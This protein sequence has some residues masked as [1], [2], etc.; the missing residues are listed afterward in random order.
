MEPDQP[1]LELL[2]PWRPLV[3]MLHIMRV[4][5]LHIMKVLTL[6]IMKVFMEVLKSAHFETAHYESVFKT[7]MEVL[8]LHIMKVLMLHTL[9]G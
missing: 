7:E 3:L 4:L 9:P 2:S 5:T 8:T 6:H 1:D